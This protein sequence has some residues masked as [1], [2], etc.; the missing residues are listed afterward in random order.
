MEEKE[1]SAPLLSRR[2]LARPLGQVCWRP[3]APAGD[4]EQQ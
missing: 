4:D 3:D 2:L 1:I